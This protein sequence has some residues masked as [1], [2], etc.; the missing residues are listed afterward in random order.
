MDDLMRQALR[1][2]LDVNPRARAGELSLLV[3]ELGRKRVNALFDGALRIAGELSSDELARLVLLFTK[4]EDLEEPNRITRE[5]TTVV[6]WLLREL[7]RRD[8][9]LAK[10]LAVWA[11]HTSTNPYIPSGST[12]RESGQVESLVESGRIDEQ[13][14]AYYAAIDEQRHEERLRRVAERAR[15]HESRRRAHIEWNARREELIAQL[16]ELDETER[17]ARV[18][19]IGTH[20]VAAFPDEWASVPAAKRLSTPTQ[21]ALAL[22]LQSAPKGPWRDFLMALREELKP[23]LASSN[24]DAVTQNQGEAGPSTGT[25]EA[26][27]VQESQNRPEK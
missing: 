9:E 5:S 15:V 20:P 24:T 16:G 4:L 6:P 8:A 13:Q 21:R 1:R 7:S 12:R 10:E 18:A 27:V 3:T 17:L 19:A 22:R 23:V 25:A 14:R 2:C 26:T 11:F